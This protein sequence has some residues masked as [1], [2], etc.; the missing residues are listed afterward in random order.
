M[1]NKT[2]SAALLRKLRKK[3]KKQPGAKVG[4]PRMMAKALTKGTAI[5]QYMASKGGYIAKK[6]KN[7]K[8]K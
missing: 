5:P 3:Y 6:K 4:D 8:K 1:S 2:I 7:T